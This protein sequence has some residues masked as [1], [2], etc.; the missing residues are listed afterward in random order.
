RIVG[1]VKRAM[2]DAGA[3]IDHVVL[4]GGMTRMPAVRD[5]VKELTGKD[6]HQGVNPDEVVAVGAAIQ[7]GVLAGDVK[8]VLLLDVTP[9]T[10]GI[11]TK[12]GVMTKLIERNTTIPTKKSEIFSTADDN[13]P[14]VEIHV[15]QGEREMA[16]GNKSLGKF[17]L[18][19]IPPAP[20]G[21]PQIEVTFDIDPNGIIHV[22]AK[23]LGTE[24]EQKI[25]IKSGSGLSEEEIQQMVSDAESH[26]DE[27]SK[28]RELAE[29]RNMAESL[30]YQSEKQ[31]EELGDKLE[32]ENKEE[33]EGAIKAVREALES[34]SKEEIDAKTEA[35]TAAMT[36]V[37]EQIYAAAQEQAA[38]EDGAEASGDDEEEEEVVDAEVVDEG[39]E[40]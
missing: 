6:P 8:D 34:D 29:A 14:S 33:I 23:D 16:G 39:D 38:S 37:S 19:G 32:S 1:P 24:K 9:L 5:R 17:Q 26:A 4:V 11:E 13:Q 25:E 2:D 31:V 21:L 35:L 20:R 7:A 3:T 30:A 10:L 36:K 12:G 40:K 22:T 15:L 28:Q 18:T 27:D